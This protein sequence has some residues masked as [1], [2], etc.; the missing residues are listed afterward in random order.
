[1]IWLLAAT[2]LAAWIAFDRLVDW[3]AEMADG[4]TCPCT[5]CGREP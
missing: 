5:L 2:A 1:M 3:I 4:A